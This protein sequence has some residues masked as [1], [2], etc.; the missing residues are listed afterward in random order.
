M[1]QIDNDLS[2]K[3]IVNDIIK[4]A[5][6]R[7]NFLYKYREM[8]NFGSR[9]TLC[10]ALIQCHFDYSCS[11][12]YPGIGKV[13]KHKLQVMQNKMMRFILDLDSRAHI[14]HK[15]FSKTG[16][17]NVETRVKQL[18]LGH[19]IKIINKTCP[20]YLLTNF[21]KLSE[22]EDRI[23]TRD[24]A[25]NFFKPRVSTDTF[26]YTAINDYNDLPN[27]IKEIQNEITFKKTLKKHLLSEAGK[28]DLKLYMYY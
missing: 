12:W 2:G 11:S 8:L 21:H 14:G 18:K 3:S 27:K 22:F 1:V 9:K 17:L 16:F 7:L 5:N 4:K 13:L 10:S 6:S 26:T 24:K 20:Y 25:N 15:E 19:V 28:V 23:V